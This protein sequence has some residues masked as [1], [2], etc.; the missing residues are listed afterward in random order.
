MEKWRK[1]LAVLYLK[2]T[3]RW[4]C[5]FHLCFTSISQF[6]N[7]LK[8]DYNSQFIQSTNANQLALARCKILFFYNV[9]SNDPNK[10]L[11]RLVF[12]NTKK[13]IKII[14]QDILSK[15]KKLTFNFN[16]SSSSMPSSITESLDR[17]CAKYQT[18]SLRP[19]ALYCIT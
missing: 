8:Y 12:S 17:L 14:S 15:R 10:K 11:S 6:N 18:A 7:C 3:K 16:Q 4:F 1:K 13:N 2:Q 5:A 19:H 9:G